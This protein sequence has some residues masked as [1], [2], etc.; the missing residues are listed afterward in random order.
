MGETEGYFTNE[1]GQNI[2]NPEGYATISEINLTRDIFS[3]LAQLFPDK[4]TTKDNTDVPES[5]KL[6][7]NQRKTINLLKID[8]NLKGSWLIPS[9]KEESSDTVGY[10]PPTTKFPSEQVIYPPEYNLRPPKRPADLSIVNENLKSMLE[11]KVV[12]KPNLNHAAFQEP[13]KPISFKSSIN[14]KMDCLFKKCLLESYTAER[15]NEIAL[16]LFPFILAELEDHFGNV[17][18]IDLPI[19]NLLYSLLS[20]T[21]HGISRMTNLHTSGLVTN[22]LE[23]RDKILLEFDHPAKTKNILRGSGFLSENSFGP[24]PESL[25]TALGSINGKELMCKAK[26]VPAFTNL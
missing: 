3:S 11:A 18:K 9:H 15:Y 17:D 7:K 8:P 23:M 5:F 1:A 16:E 14:S 22:K 21:G 20:L 13:K 2:P 12:D 25:K 4:F 10:W 26:V 6:F 19:F 24:L